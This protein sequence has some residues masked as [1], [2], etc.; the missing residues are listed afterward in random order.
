MRLLLN[1]VNAAASQCQ[2]N[3]IYTC[4]YAPI[5]ANSGSIKSFYKDLYHMA[6]RKCSLYPR[7]G[8][9][10]DKIILVKGLML[11]CD[12]KIWK[13]FLNK[14]FVSSIFMKALS[15]YEFAYGDQ[16]L[17]IVL[18]MDHMLQFNKYIEL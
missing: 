6:I 11:S 3:S 9:I 16:K 14:W 10:L 12:F 17:A 5:L 4:L 7:I 13:V 15:F 2:I 18:F 8:H 1:T